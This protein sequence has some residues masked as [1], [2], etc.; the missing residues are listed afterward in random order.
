[1]VIIVKQYNWSKYSTPELAPLQ[2]IVEHESSI[3][4][5]HTGPLK[6]VTHIPSAKGT[7]EQLLIFGIAL[8]SIGFVASKAMIPA[9]PLNVGGFLWMVSF[10][11]T[12]AILTNCMRA[13]VDGEGRRFDR[14]IDRFKERAAMIDRLDLIEEPVAIQVLPGETGEIGS[15]TYVFF[16]GRLAKKWATDHSTQ[17]SRNPLKIIVT[18]KNEKILEIAESPGKNLISNHLRAKIVPIRQ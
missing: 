6:L 9:N 3:M 11:V 4:A 5:W 8:S 2:Q 18:D 7:G 1:M 15:K 14:R 13:G 12:G 10:F 16:Q 17:I